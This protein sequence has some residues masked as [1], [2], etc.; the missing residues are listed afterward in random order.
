MK[1]SQGIAGVDPD[2]T[3]VEPAG[4]PAGAEAVG[5]ATLDRQFA[6]LVARET[7]ARE[8]VS[9]RSRSNGP[10]MVAFSIFCPQSDRLNAERAKIDQVCPS[11][12]RDVCDT[13]LFRPGRR[14]VAPVDILLFLALAGRRRGHDIAGEVITTREIRL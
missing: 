3:N 13:M 2:S 14:G 4:V 5:R 7:D 10:L 12:T 1:D 9:L 11:S 6:E 8:E